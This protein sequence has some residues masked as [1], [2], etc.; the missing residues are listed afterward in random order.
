MS[1]LLYQLSYTATFRKQAVDY[2]TVVRPETNHSVC[3]EGSHCRWH[4]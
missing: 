3:S 1:P 4:S 2:I